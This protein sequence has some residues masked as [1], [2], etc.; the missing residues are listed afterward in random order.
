MRFILWLPFVLCAGAAFAQTTVLNGTSG[1]ATNSSNFSTGTSGSTITLTQGFF[2]DYL[3]VGGGGGGGS[4]HGGGG[5]G[6]GMLTGSTNISIMDYS[7]TV[8]AG[9]AGTPQ[10]S[11]S[12]EGQTA[13]IQ[14]KNGSNSMAFGLTALGGGAGGGNGR[15]VRT[16]GPHR[17]PSCRQHADTGAARPGWRRCRSYNR[18]G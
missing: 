12:Q 15:R 14:P 13:L 5:G 7:V 4:R 11:R 10:H 1:N 8:G 16:H 3:I 18:E 17:S 2:V 6:G 9:G